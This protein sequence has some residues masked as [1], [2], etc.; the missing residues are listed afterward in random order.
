ML[1]SEL[2]PKQLADGIAHASAPPMEFRGSR[3]DLKAWGQQ[4]HRSVYTGGWPPAEEGGPLL[5]V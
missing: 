2:T 4:S 1:P 3:G 5:P